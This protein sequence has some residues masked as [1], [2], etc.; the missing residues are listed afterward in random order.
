MIATSLPPTSIVR[1][2]TSGR[3]R[4]MIASAARHSSGASAV[5]PNSFARRPSAGTWRRRTAADSTSVPASNRNVIWSLLSRS[6]SCSDSW[7]VS[8]APMPATSISAALPPSLKRVRSAA[9]SCWPASANARSPIAPTTRIRSPSTPASASATAAMSSIAMNRSQSVCA[10]RGRGLEL[11]DDA[12]HRRRVRRLIARDGQRE[13]GVRIEHDR[14]V[15]RA[16]LELLAQPA[17]GALAEQRAPHAI[18]HAG[19]RRR[20]RRRR[21]SRA[22]ASRLP[23]SRRGRDDRARRRAGRGHE[24]DVRPSRQRRHLV[25]QIRRATSVRI[26]ITASAHSWAIWVL[27]SVVADPMCGAKTTRGHREQPRMRSA[28]RRRRRRGPPRRVVRPRARRRAR[29][30]RRSAPRAVLTRIAVGFIAR[31]PRAHRRGRGS[32]A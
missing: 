9:R 13:R 32:P 27:A 8:S 10:P 24:Q 14:R 12:D 23:R 25:D 7:P 17:L 1:A 30:R 18:G 5:A 20:P 31:Q 3:G 4:A 19:R 16:D 21:R 28:A 11:R 6:E 15:G 29:P 22:R 2:I 26:A